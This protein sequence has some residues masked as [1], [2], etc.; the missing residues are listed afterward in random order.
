MG[1]IVAAVATAALPAFAAEQAPSSAD[2]A[3]QSNADLQ[4]QIQALK[5]QVSDL[6]RRANEQQNEKWLTEERAAE[7]KA[8]V[9]NVLADS[10]QHGQY[11]DSDVMAGYKNGFYVKTADD[12]F[13][14][15]FNG[16]VQYR[17][18]FEQAHQNNLAAFPRTPGG[19]ANGFDFRYARLT[20]DGN[21]FTPNL[22]YVFTG[23]FGSN[24]N[25]AGTNN[26]FQ[27]VDGFIAYR[28]NDMLNVRA[29]AFITP[30]SRVLVI[31]SGLQFVDFPTVFRPFNQDRTTG[32]SLYGDIIKDK[33]TYEINVNDGGKNGNQLGRVGDSSST[34]AYDNRLSFATREAYYGGT[35]TPADF[36]D[37]SDLRKDNTSLA[38]MVGFGADYDSAN[39]S[40]G[41]FP[42][43]QGSESIVGIGTNNA[44]G[45][46]NYPLNGDIYRATV[47]GS[48]K[49]MG[50]AFTGATF[51]EEINENPAVAGQTIGNP[52]SSFPSGYSATNKSSFFLFSYYGQVGYML[53]KQWEVVARAG[54]LMTEGSPNTMQEYAMGVNYYIYGKNVKLQGD[55]S[56]IPSEA[57]FTD[58]TFATTQNTQDIAVRLQLQVKW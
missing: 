16:F 37:E 15:K 41:A 44:S 43:I 55:V 42:G 58:T 5:Q 51:F 6:Q 10:K 23:D 12:N 27:L 40:S 29:G 31:A 30:F 11:L 21:L 38:W 25:S 57:A 26:N 24:A 39:T 22:T 54:S 50:F 28:F 36:Q 7:I 2:S 34:G 52:A 17:Y 13:T 14:M 18:T 1:A 19:D 35:G 32:L 20:F 46:A 56:Y 9:T 47:D 49:Y 33:L 8:I 4:S 45:F 48:F 3:V 53:N